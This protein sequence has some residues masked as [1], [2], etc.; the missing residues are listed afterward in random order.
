MRYL[1]RKEQRC[2]ALKNLQNTKRMAWV[3]VGKNGDGQESVSKLKRDKVLR[4][5]EPIQA[6]TMTPEQCQQMAS[7]RQ[8]SLVLSTPRVAV[9]TQK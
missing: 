5:K 1:K 6:A 3:L 2:A 4:N 8:G 7:S 9:I